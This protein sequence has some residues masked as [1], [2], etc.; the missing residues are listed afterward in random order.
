MTKD[1]ASQLAPGFL[2]TVHAFI[3]KNTS[4]AVADNSN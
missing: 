1:R 4:A 2:P 3:H